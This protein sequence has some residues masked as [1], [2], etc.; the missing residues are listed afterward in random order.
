MAKVQ[1]KNHNHNS[2]FLNF[3]ENHEQAKRRKEKKKDGIQPS[4]IVVCFCGRISVREGFKPS[5]TIDHKTFR[6]FLYEFALRNNRSFGVDSYHIH[7]CLQIFHIANR[8]VAVYL[9]ALYHLS[10][11]VH[12]LDFRN[13]FR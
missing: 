10:H 8:I 1:T 5:L 7:P 6:L 2:F 11:H 9:N 4:L 3:M 12:N 13:C